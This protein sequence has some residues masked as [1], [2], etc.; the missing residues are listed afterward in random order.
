[1]KQ[2]LTISISLCM[3]AACTGSNTKKDPGAKE[4][5][6]PRNYAITPANAYNDIFLDSLAME[7]YIGTAKLNDTIANAMRSFYNARNYQFAW[8][9]SKGLSEQALGFRSLYDYSKDSSESKALEAKLDDLV[10]EDSV[11]VTP[12]DAGY[13]KTELQLTQRFLQYAEKTFEDENIRRE[14]LAY[15][16]PISKNK[17]LP[18]ADSILADKENRRYAKS[19]GNYGELK[20]QLARYREIAQKG[21]WPALEIDKKKR[22]KKG[23]QGPEILAIKKRLAVTGELNAADTS[24]VFDDALESGVKIFQQRHGYTGTGVVSDTLI[25]QMNVPVLTRIQQLLINMERMRWLPARPEGKL[26]MVNIPEFMLH[27][28]ENGK[29]AFDMP[30]VVGKEGHST[31]MFFGAMNQVVFSPYWNIPAS[32]VR[33]EILPAQGRNASYL[34]N[35]NMEV[36][37]ERNGLPVVRQKPGPK[38]SLGKV[39]FLFPNSFNI[40]FHDTPAKDLFNRDNRAYSHGCIRLSDP[41]KMANYVLQDNPDWTAEKIDSAMNAG[42]EKYVK[43][44]DPLP[45]MITYYTAWVD[46]NKTLHF[47]DDIYNHDGAVARKM[48]EDPQ[49][50]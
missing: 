25:R 23:D 47:R 49:P 26:L 2:I 16:I 3:L 15:F 17:I 21:G 5:I 50:E 24:A 10:G 27:A 19:N 37:G 33:K 4:S 11:D 43:I 32:I 28:T 9:S 48:F 42:K 13:I 31:V 46:D 38:N 6:V 40:Y 18:M 20:E 39:K 12:G 22:F 36:T 1:M 14:Q 45:V 35:N 41:A 8:F 7:K 34:E 30:V 29:S 44:K